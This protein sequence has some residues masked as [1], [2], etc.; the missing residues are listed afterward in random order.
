MLDKKKKGKRETTKLVVQNHARHEVDQNK[1]HVAYYYHSRL[2]YF[3][4]PYCFFSRF[5]TSIECSIPSPLPPKF[6]KE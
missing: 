4:I 2:S 6:T 3:K 5:S 1:L